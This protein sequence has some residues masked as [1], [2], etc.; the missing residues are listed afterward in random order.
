MNFTIRKATLLYNLTNVCKALST[1]VQMPGL[2]GILFVVNKNSIELTTSNN[3]ISIKVNISQDLEVM[4]E[5]RFVI[6]GKSLIEII[7]KINSDEVEFLSYEENTIKIMAGKGVFTLNELQLES[8]PNIEFNTT[9]CN[10]QI[11]A[12]NLKQIIRKTSF[13]ISPSESRLVLTGVSIST[14]KN[15]L[16]F[17]ATDSFRLA[18]K[19]IFFENELPTL[20]TIIP[21]KSLDELNKILEESEGIVDIYASSSKI[22]FKYQNLLFQ[23]RV[24][25]GTFPNV[26]AIIP[27]KFC[28]TVKFEKD[29]IIETIDRVSIFVYNENSNIIKLII[30]DDGNVELSAN[31]NEIGG[32]VE[33]I[34]PLS[35]SSKTPFEV[36]FSSK[37]LLDALKTFDSKEIEM[38]FTGEIKPMTITGEFDRNLIQIILPLRG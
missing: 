2:T 34:V 28:L 29:K 33:E 37:Y 19:Q 7:K 36:A 25:N 15:L 27:D 35:I 24:I 11:D 26:E 9:Q 21:G 3:D 32:A 8:F 22:L 1:K 13:A 20:K 31:S 14:N 5:G 30:N 12:L 38:N 6:Q 4:E 23:S 10:F 16:E 17:S 18:R